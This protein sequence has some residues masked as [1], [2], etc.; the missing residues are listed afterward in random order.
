[1]ETFDHRTAKALRCRAT[2]LGIRTTNLTRIA[3]ALRAFDAARVAIER[4]G[5]RVVRSKGD[6]SLF[7]VGNATLN[8]YEIVQYAQ[9]L[10]AEK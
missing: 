3:V 4:S 9:N 10:D 1:M 7:F 8:W 5:R 2:T 6:Y